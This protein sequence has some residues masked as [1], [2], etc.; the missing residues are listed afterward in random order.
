L[1]CAGA[2][3]CGI[4]YSFTKGTKKNDAKTFGDDVTRNAVVKAR[5]KV[6]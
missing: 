1:N 5:R 6:R 2:H 3:T 4:L